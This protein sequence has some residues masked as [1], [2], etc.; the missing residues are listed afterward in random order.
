MAGAKEKVH[1][2]NERARFSWILQEMIPGF[3]LVVKRV[4]L[5]DLKLPLCIDYMIFY[6]HFRSSKEF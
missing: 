2:F 3:D 4:A 1:A 5:S 6:D